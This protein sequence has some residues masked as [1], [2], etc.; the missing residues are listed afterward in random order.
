[1]RIDRYGRIEI[2]MTALRLIF[3]AVV[4][5]QTLVIHLGS[6]NYVMVLFPFATWIVGRL[7]AGER[8]TWRVWRYF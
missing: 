7:C 2:S 8:P 1:M 5:L 3:V 4:V 6:K